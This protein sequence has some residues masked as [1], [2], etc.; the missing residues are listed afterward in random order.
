MLSNL[1]AE[2]LH[3]MHDL[4]QFLYISKR[5]DKEIYML[6]LTHNNVYEMKCFVSQTV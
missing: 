3:H 6:Q 4:V 2:A 5:L 1:G